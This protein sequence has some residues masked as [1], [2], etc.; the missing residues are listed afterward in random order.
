[1]NKKKAPP[2]L[3]IGCKVSVGM[4][5]NERG[6]RV[7]LPD[8]RRVSAF[9]DKRHVIVNRDPKPGKE[10]DGRI[11]VSVVEIKRDS[12]IVDLPEPAFDTGPR[13]RVPK[14]FLR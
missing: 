11:K 10:V 5:S 4:F 8:G 12:A 9:V 13:L 14:T 3:T 6:V 2:E 1:M 7:D